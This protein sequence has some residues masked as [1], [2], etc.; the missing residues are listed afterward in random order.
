[1]NNRAVFLDRDGVINRNTHYIN[2]PE[3]F[4]I[5]PNV[6]DAIKLLHEARYKIFV[7]TNQGGIEKGLIEEDA[8]F[9]IHQKMKLAIPEIYDIAFCPNYDSFERKPQP[10]MIY[11]LAYEYE[12]Y[13]GESWFVGDMV[14]DCIAGKRAGCKTIMVKTD[15]ME[16][17]RYAENPNVDYQVDE[18][19]DAALMIL[20]MDGF[21]I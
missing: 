14:T 17:L 3:D 16:S 15:F 11:N 7:V 8:L 1:M 20:R 2:K 9:R 6:Q 5:L 12:I 19:M 4:E 18:L 21:D 10:G 13:T